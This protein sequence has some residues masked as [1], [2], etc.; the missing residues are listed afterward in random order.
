[1]YVSN[2]NKFGKLYRVMMQASP[3]ARVSPET[4]KQVKVRNGSEMAPIDNFVKL[5]RIYGPDIINRFNMF[6]SIAITGTPAASYS[7]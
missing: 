7:S 3:E 2:F 5:T 6:T 1:M 4:L